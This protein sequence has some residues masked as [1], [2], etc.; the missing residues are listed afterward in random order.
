[1]PLDQ[2]EVI[3]PSLSIGLNMAPRSSTGS[4]SHEALME[5]LGRIPVQH[6]Q[7]AKRVPA[8][9]LAGAVFH[10]KVDL[11]GVGVFEGPSAEGVLLFLHQ[12]DG[13]GGARVGFDAGS[14][15]KIQTPQDVVVPAS[16][17]RKLRPSGSITAP[18][19]SDRNR[20]RSRRYSCPRRRA[21]V[22]AVVAPSAFSY[23]NNP[24]RTQI[25]EWNEDRLL[26]GASQF[27]PPSSNCS[28]EADRPD[29]RWPR[30]SR[31]PRRGPAR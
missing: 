27:Q 28:Q 6:A 8:A 20:L 22:T 13:L 19:D 29:D 26:G 4:I 17:K 30:R 1:M 9:R 31:H 10:V 5:S 25:V 3:L 16:R 18:V 21:S 24:S 23:S 11:T 15:Q 14:P 12:I 7:G 2:L